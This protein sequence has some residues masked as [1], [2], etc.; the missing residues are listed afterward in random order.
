MK[1]SAKKA[2]D[3]RNTNETFYIVIVGSGA[4]L[5]VMEAALN[6]G[7]SCAIIE[8]AKFG[9]TCLTKGCIPS[10]MLVYPADF[11]RE[12]EESQR[13]GIRRSRPEIDWDAI[14]KRMWEQIDFS[15]S[16]E[17]SLQGIPNLTV[18]KGSGAFTE[19]NN[20]VISCEG[21]EDEIIY[22]DSSFSE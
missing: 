18:Y 21:K 13:I 19:P 14:S 4:G 10:K 15:K 5:M 16:I 6:K 17:H 3:I 12:A 20:M 8:K 11:I 9:G 22:G 2:N 1:A 7:L